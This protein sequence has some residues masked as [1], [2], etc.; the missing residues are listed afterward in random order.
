MTLLITVLGPNT[1]FFEDAF[2]GPLNGLDITVNSATATQVVTT[3]PE[4]GHVTTLTGTGFTFDALG[5]FTGGT[6][7]GL[8][9]NDGTTTGV[10]MT[11]M[12]W[13]AVAFQ[14]ALVAVDAGDYT[15]VDAMLSLQ[16]VTVDGSA[17]AVGI[18]D[19][20][21]SGVTS[22]V[23]ITG[24][25]FDDLIGGGLGDDTITP[26]TNT[27]YDV[28]IGSLGN[29][30]IDFAGANFASYYEIRYVHEGFDVVANAITVDINGNTNT[31]SISTVGGLTTVLNINSALH[32]DGL[33]IRGTGFADTFNIDSGAGGWSQYAGMKGN[34]TF[35]ITLTGTVRISYSDWD[36]AL[37]PTQGVNVNL[38][39]G[40]V[41]N[42]GW[43]N[44]DQINVLGGTG[45]LAIR[46]TNHNDTILGSDGNER[47]I[48]RAGTDT[49]D[50]GGGIDEVRYDRSGVGAVTIDL[51]AQTGTGTWNGL[52]FNHTLVNVENLRGSRTGDD[53]L[54][55]DDADN[56]FQGRGGNDTLSGRGGNDILI[57][58]T[59]NDI[60]DGGLGSDYA[61]YSG[62]SG[63]VQVYLNLH[64][65]F[66]ADGRD[67]L[68]NIENLHGSNFS[69]RLIGDAGNNILIG[70]SGNDVIK[71]KGGNDTAFGDDGNDKIVG[72]DGDET[73]F[74]GNGQDILIGNKGVDTLSGGSGND[75]LYGG[76]DNDTLNGDAGNDVLRGNRGNDV[77]NGGDASDR[78]Y[79]GG[80]NDT[81]NGDAGVDYLYGENGNDILNGGAGNDSM[82][83]G[84]GADIFVF[85]AMATTNSDRVKDFTNGDDKLD[86]SS[87]GFGTFADVQ[88]VSFDLGWALKLNFGG[89]NVLYLEGFALADFD[90]S[91]VIL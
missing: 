91:D 74:G 87:F 62:A 65:S 55:G 18:N 48:L 22:A 90:A 67:T 32:S 12:S 29:D 64:K 23:S 54:L 51:A 43:G 76:R 78:M 84:A 83:G 35:N 37:S 61:I 69:D 75:Y 52:A 7:T 82:T 14:S 45:I 57:G 73:F 79:G 42:D 68:T 72:F 24:S 26:G 27:G 11:G 89:S 38:V 47:F 30:T 40:V 16:P 9:F 6:I 39:T 13:S 80:N 3:Q 8:S 81:L 86:L 34:D 88:A 15:Q 85:E 19:I 36:G 46:G 44:V 33:G 1:R 20:T 50:A 71:S 63:A 70:G 10:V 56:Q 28:I 77:L 53:T 2:F 59:G 5:N 58:G 25:R 31:G 21:L 66:G 4:T 60:I 17:S 49:L 41:S